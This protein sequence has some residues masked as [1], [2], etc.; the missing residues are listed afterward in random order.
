MQTNKNENSVNRSFITVILMFCT[1]LF[2]ASVLTI[3]IAGFKLSVFRLLIIICFAYL[4]VTSNKKYN[5]YSAIMIFWLLWGI[6]SF[7][8]VSDKGEWFKEVFFLIVAATSVEFFS[9][10]MDSKQLLINMCEVFSLFIGIHNI[11]GYYEIITR[12]YS[13]VS[14]ELAKTY[15]FIYGHIPVSVFFNSNNY[16]TVLLFGVAITAIAIKYANPKMKIIYIIIMASSLLQIFLSLSRA[17]L[18]ALTIGVIVFFFIKRVKNHNKLVLFTMLLVLFG[19]VL[20]TPI[21][22]SIITK[23]GSFFNFNISNGSESL[24]ITLLH[25]GWESFKKTYFWGTGAGNLP[26]MINNISGIAGGQL[27]FWWLEVLFTYGPLIWMLYIY[28][29]IKLLKDNFRG[30]AQGSFVSRVLVSYMLAYIVGACSSSSVMSLE[31]TWIAWAFIIGYRVN[32]ES[33]G[34]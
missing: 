32:Y 7:I 11:I 30:T 4:C 14:P 16:A 26:V 12:N 19:I 8:F 9:R 6:V 31:P 10:K 25:Y 17:N 23:V 20:V 15:G 18:I 22:T 29:Y 1:S 13:W 33:I 27:H 3:N 5:I 28:S 34:L 2:A 21:G 24:R